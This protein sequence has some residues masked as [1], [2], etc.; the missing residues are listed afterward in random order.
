MFIRD[1][2]VMN[3]ETYDTSQLRCA[4]MSILNRCLGRLWA[5]QISAGICCS[6][7]PTTLKKYMFKKIVP[8]RRN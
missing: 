5:A 4:F 2:S 7:R 8:A 6:S 1:P 3:S